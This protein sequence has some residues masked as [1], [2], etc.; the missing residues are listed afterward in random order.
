MSKYWIVGAMFGGSD[1]AFD[2]FIK[3]GYWYCW[4]PDIE[5]DGEAAVQRQQEKVK[6]IV[7]GDRIAI[8]RML[9]RGASDIEIRAIGIVTDIDHEE[10]RIYVKWLLEFGN[11]NPRLVPLNGAAASIHGPYEDNDPWVHRV[12]SI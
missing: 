10:W 1:D 9:G 2:I 7:P 3:R 8:K 12:F 6:K 11:K 5:Y 4:E